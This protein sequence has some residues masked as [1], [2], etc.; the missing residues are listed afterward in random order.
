[1]ED[2]DSFENTDIPELI[3]ILQKLDTALDNTDFS[4]IESA[5]TEME[6][7]GVQGL[8]EQIKDAVLIMDYESAK[9]IITPILEDAK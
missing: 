6:T 4:A 7:L 5:I 1:V 9:K 8:L 3:P 2:T